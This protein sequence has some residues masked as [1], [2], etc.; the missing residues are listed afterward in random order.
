MLLRSRFTLRKLLAIQASKRCADNP[1]LRGFSHL[2]PIHQEPLFRNL[3]TCQAKHRNT[4]KDTKVSATILPKKEDKEA[5]QTPETTSPV[6][7]VLAPHLQPVDLS[8]AAAAANNK[9]IKEQSLE[10]VKPAEKATI[11]TKIKEKLIGLD[12][13][14]EPK[15]PTAKPLPKKRKKVDLTAQSLERNFITPV[16]AM[17]D[18]L[19][20]PSELESLPKT[21]RRSP[22][23]TEPPITVYW[24]RDV[25]AKALEVWGSKEALHKELIK[26]DIERKKYQQNIFTVKRRLRDYRRELGKSAD[27]IEDES[28]LMG[29]SG[30]VV[31]TAVVINGTNCLFKLFAWLYTGS[32]SMFSECIHSLADTINQLILAYGIHK[33]I[34]IADS[35]HPYGYSNMKYV[36][37]LISGVG[38]FCVGTGLSFY[39]GISGLLHPQPMEDFFWAYFILGGSLVSE[40]ATW[41]VAFNSIRKGA[42]EINMSVKDYIFRGQDPSVNVVLLEDFA[43]VVGVIV[44]AGC[45]GISSATNNPIPDALGSLLVGCILG[46]VASFIIYTNVA[47]LVG[48]SIPE[49]NLERINAELEKDVMIRAIHD[50]KGIDMG[51]YLVRYKAE[52]DFDGRE[53]ARSY[54]DKQDL[55]ELLE[56]ARKLENIDQLEEFMLKH[57]ENIVDLMGGEIDRIEMKLRKKHPEIRHCDLEVL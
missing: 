5:S 40:G 34:Q 29:R 44:A 2:S 39:H 33:S 43:A 50:V 38:I 51:N 36:A 7:K 23:E 26:R 9:N 42:R 35:Y 25:E 6:I 20:K 41:L 45:M 55:N 11:T 27:I 12:K 53:L 16:R 17:S 3:K 4:S 14:D 10:S 57:G 46:S 22:Y 48:R 32:H 30:R 52:L 31:L 49:E 19:L 13:K 18:F 15:E 8:A 37:S 24:R 54:L 56:E 1:G 21:K 47:A 28:G